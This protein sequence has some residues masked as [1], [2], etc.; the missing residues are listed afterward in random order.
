[1]M[2]AS[3]YIGPPHRIAQQYQ[4]TGNLFIVEKYFQCATIPSLTVRVYL[5]SLAVVASRTCQLAQNSEKIW[6][7]CRSKAHI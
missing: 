6:T 2:H 4:R 1:M 5:H 7:Y 3:H